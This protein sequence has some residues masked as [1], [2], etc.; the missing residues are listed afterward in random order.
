[1]IFNEIGLAM[2]VSAESKNYQACRNH[3]KIRN[4]YYLIWLVNWVRLNLLDDYDHVLDTLSPAIITLRLLR[5]SLFLQWCK[6][7]C[8]K[9]WNWK[10]YRLTCKLILIFKI[11]S[12]RKISKQTVIISLIDFHYTL[13]IE[14]ADLD[15]LIRS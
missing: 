10:C 3:Q 4:S 1:M 2:S 8:V 9:I 14:N 15:Q 7:S 13:K 12:F 5:S 6:Q 11:L